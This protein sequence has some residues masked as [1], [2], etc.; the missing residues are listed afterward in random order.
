M[1]YLFILISAF[2]LWTAC[3]PAPK[4]TTPNETTSQVG[5][6][7]AAAKKVTN[8]SALPR[9]KFRYDLKNP[10]ETIKL[11]SKLVEISGLSLSPDG[12]HII[13]VNDEEGK[14]FYLNK[15][16]GEIEKTVKFGKSGDYEGLETVDDK[17]FVVKNNGDIYRVKD[18]DKE[19]PKTKDYNTE[20]NSSFDVEGLGYDAK[21]NQLLLACKGK[22]GDGDNMKGKRAVY[23]FDLEQHKL[24]KQPAYLIDRNTIGKYFKS[25]GVSQQLVDLLT[26]EYASDAFGP[27]GIAIHPKTSDICIV[28]SVGKLFLILD[29]SGKIVYMQKLDASIYRQPEGICFDKDGTLYISSEG[30]G[31]KGRLFKFYRK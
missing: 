13:A 26:P 23:S 6:D 5:A 1:K 8:A 18:L 31:G 3:E 12:Q 2:S 11:S 14:I 25:D 7:S 30:K 15:K 28:S 21:S 19:E 9:Y 4:S 10:D 27:S 24:S 17:I 22:A 29:R 20:L 16:T